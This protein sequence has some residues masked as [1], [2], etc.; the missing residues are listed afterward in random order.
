MKIEV[1]AEG[2][3][4]SGKSFI[5]ERI[6]EEMKAYGFDSNPVINVSVD[7]ELLTLIRDEDR[8][9]FLTGDRKLI[10]GN[11]EFEINKNGELMKVLHAGAEINTEEVNIN[12]ARGALMQVS[13]EA[14][15]KKV[16]V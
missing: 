5:L 7:R 6:R 2:L 14:T 13:L 3:P 15:L 12:L 4:R 8:M 1:Y 16:G 11:W 10:F 9:H